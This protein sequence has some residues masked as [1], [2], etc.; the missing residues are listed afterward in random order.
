MT[1]IVHL[2]D[3]HF[4][5]H[6]AALVDALLARIA[7]ARADL[8]VVTGDL[9]HRGTAA[10]YQAAAAFLRQISAPVLAVPGN[11]DMPAFDPLT[12]LRDPLMHWRHHIAADPAPLR[13]VGQLRVIGLNSADPW[14]WQRG[15]IRAADRARVLRAQAQGVTN[16]IALHHPLQHRPGIDKSL[17]RGAR[18]LL[19]GLDDGGRHVVLTGHLH[20]WSAGAF[21][22][23]APPG[24]P[25]RGVLQIQAGTAL[26]ARPGDRQ[27][28][29]CVIES[30][31]PDLRIERHI[32]P[33]AETGFAPPRH[34]A[35]RHV[36]GGWQAVPPPDA[37]P[38]GAGGG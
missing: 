27:N 36:D 10:Q 17:A 31:G 14:A 13:D 26:C 21:L 1:R 7:A 16:L 6:R 19:A 3:L 22:P 33:M 24:G 38:L 28:E 25:G 12:R 8:V 37:G 32:A 35:F 18:R 34:L 30:D 11:H 23:P 9:T 15:R 29:F 5:F 2:S 4:G 20:L